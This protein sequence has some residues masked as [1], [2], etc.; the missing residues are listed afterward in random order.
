MP[1]MLGEGEWQFTEDFS[2]PLSFIIERKLALESMQ[3]SVSQLEEI[4]ASEAN[5]CLMP[6]K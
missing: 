4:V 2:R 3:H 6:S 5:I 1:C